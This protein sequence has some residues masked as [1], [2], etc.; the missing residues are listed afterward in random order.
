MGARAHEMPPECVAMYNLFV[1]QSCQDTLAACSGTQA[2]G[3]CR[4]PTQLLQ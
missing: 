3:A 2:P 1:E 4:G